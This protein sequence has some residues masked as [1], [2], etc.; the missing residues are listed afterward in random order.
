MDGHG[1]VQLSFDIE[2]KYPVDHV[3]WLASPGNCGLNILGLDFLSKVG[4][5]V[6][7]NTPMLTLGNI[8][9]NKHVLLA[10]QCKKDFPF[11]AEIKFLSLSEATNIP[12]QKITMVKVEDTSDNKTIFIPHKRLRHMGLFVYNTYMVN[13]E[14]SIPL[15]FENNN[16]HP[17]T[18][19]KG[20]VGYL[21][22]DKAIPNRSKYTISDFHNFTDQCLQTEEH[23]PI[24]YSA[25]CEWIETVKS[26][27]TELETDFTEEAEAFSES[28]KNPKGTKTFPSQILRNFSIETQKLLKQFD[29]SNSV[30]TNEELLK[31]ANII[32]VDSDVYSKHKFD[33]GKIPEEFRIELKPDAEF[34]KQRPSRVPIN[35]RDKLDTL[36]LKL[37]DADII[38]EM[39]DE[40]EMGSSFI[41]PI[42]IVPKGEIVK[43]VIDARYLNSITDLSSYSW[44]LEPLP[45]L[46]TK[47]QGY[48]FST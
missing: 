37:Q 2:S 5:S 21:S 17:V 29:V 40:I 31:L 44:P 18:I 4:N 6:H 32:A 15:L 36:L 19:R 30:L 12:S 39:G 27:N 26:D 7:L 43:L 33:V 42:I 10:Q 1:S 16:T 45:V 24:Q 34:R 11:F 38:R 35:Y 20:P 8:Y 47:I 25:F 48:Y 41:N 28:N 22:R 13:Q 9:P 14:D 23:L 3:F 46:L